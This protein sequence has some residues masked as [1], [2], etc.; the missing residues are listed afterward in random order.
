MSD[1]YPPGV[2]GA[3][4]QI[5][6]APEPDEPTPPAPVTY[7]RSYAGLSPRY[8]IG[9]EIPGPHPTRPYTIVGLRLRPDYRESHADDEL[10]IVFD[11][12]QWEYLLARVTDDKVDAWGWE[13]EDEVRRRLES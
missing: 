8:A 4:P 2:T 5:A 9:S 7:L 11:K 13:T 10:R 3:E 1:Y 6:G 12:V